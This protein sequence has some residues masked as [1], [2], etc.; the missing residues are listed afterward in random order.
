MWYLGKVAT[1]SGRE[2]LILEA[3]AAILLHGESLLSLSREAEHCMLPLT[4]P[5]LVVYANSG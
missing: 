3:V 5:V 4:T 2:A 1:V